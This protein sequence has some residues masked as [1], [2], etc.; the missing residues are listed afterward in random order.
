MSAR[1]QTVPEL[2]ELCARFEL[3]KTG[4]KQDLIDRLV[5]LYPVGGFDGGGGAGAGARGDDGGGGG[6]AEGGGEV[7]RNRH[8]NILCHHNRQK[9][10]CKECGGSSFCEHGRRRSRCKECGGS[11]I[12]EYGRQRSYCKACGGKRD[13][14]AW[15]REAPV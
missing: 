9:S 10:K 8:G 15:P 13:L 7:R 2:K 1:A 5:V 6:N 12:C 14:R 11:E 4:K 3:P